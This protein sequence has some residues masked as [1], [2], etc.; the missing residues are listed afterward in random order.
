M[1]F[2]DFDKKGMAKLVSNVLI[3]LFVGLLLLPA[4]TLSRTATTTTDYATLT[5]M[6]LLFGKL[7]DQPYSNVSLTATN[8]LLIVCLFLLILVVFANLF[9]FNKFNVLKELV[10]VGIV[11]LTTLAFNN[12]DRSF[13]IANKVSLEGVVKMLP[14]FKICGAILILILAIQT[15]LAILEVREFQFNEI[16]HFS[17]LSG[18]YILLLLSLFIPVVSIGNT[19]DVLRFSLMQLMNKIN[20][21]SDVF[22]CTYSQAYVPA[23]LV[24]VFIALSYVSQLVNRYV[25]ED[26]LF[27]IVSFILNFTSLYFFI[28]LLDN[29][30]SIFD[31]TS[32]LNTSLTAY[33]FI[34]IILV[35]FLTCIS[36]K[37]LLES[38][39]SLELLKI[40]IIL[41]GVV[42]ISS[43]YAK[44]YYLFYDYTGGSISNKA[45]YS[46]IELFTLEKYQSQPIKNV[47]FIIIPILVLVSTCLTIGVSKYEKI[48]ALVSSLVSFA[49]LIIFISSLIKG[50]EILE[51]SSYAKCQLYGTGYFNLI[52]LLVMSIGNLYLGATLKFRKAELKKNINKK[53]EQNFAK[54]LKKIKKYGINE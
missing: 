4:L 23:I 20:Y 5:G 43:I 52:A 48:G 49:A 16:T 8:P 1:K 46:F 29:V 27:E 25:K 50:F 39:N 24:F 42:F 45:Y 18:A 2:I 44:S 54:I 7:L 6:D 11:A 35:T 26:K 10:V 3:V 17:I 36:L 41:V 33:G 13:A 30:S 32:V 47:Y 28:C 34:S 9:D 31:T 14:G 37:K 53:Q 12:A 38:V 40:F 21:S 19:K 15:I 51:A 22:A